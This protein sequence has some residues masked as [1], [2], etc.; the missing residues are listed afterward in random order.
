MAGIRH[1]ILPRFLLK[2]FASRLDGDKVFTWVYRKQ[3][4]PFEASTKD[5]S[6]AKHFY[7]KDGDINVDSE[8]TDMEGGYSSLVDEL[9]NVNEQTEIFVLQV[10]EFIT[11]LTVRTKHL[12]DSFR[13]SSEFLIEKL[14]E[15]YSDFNNLKGLFQRNPE[16]LRETVEKEFKD[17]SLSQYQMNELIYRA[18]LLLPSL[19]EQNKTELQLMFQRIFSGIRMRVPTMVKEGHIKALAKSLVPEP[20][21][22]DYRSLHWFVGKSEAPFVLGDFGCMF[23]IDAARRFR[24]FNNE[25]DPIKNIFLPLSS[26]QILVGTSLPTVPM[27]DGKVIN[28][29]TVKCCREFFLSSEPSPVFDGLT[30][31]MG[32]ESEIISKEELE[33]IVTELFDSPNNPKVTGVKK[34]HGG[35]R[36]KKK[37]R[38][39]R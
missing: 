22:D 38:E 23:E 12:R 16:L 17:S 10:P 1:H 34:S 13:E 18:R 14:Y 32:E 19:L 8:I 29:A 39:R 2:G 37:R 27:I 36:S 28:Y 24:T 15:H 9:R 25:D 30:S 21:V 4:K 3:D 26:N 7:G 5:I 31:L 20:R 6:V 11:H 35:K 33:A